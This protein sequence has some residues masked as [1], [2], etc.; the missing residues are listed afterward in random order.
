MA[1]PREQQHG[2][3]P[4]RRGTLERARQETAFC[5]WKPSRVRDVKGAQRS[6]ERQTE[7]KRSPEQP[8]P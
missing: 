8:G 5:T 4:C 7:R 6:A 3:G 2:C 1:D